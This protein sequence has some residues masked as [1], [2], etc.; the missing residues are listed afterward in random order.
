MA[1]PCLRDVLHGAG[2]GLLLLIAFPTRARARFFRAR[3]EPD[4]LE[5]QD[6]GKLELDMQVGALYGDGVDGSRVILPDMDLEI[7]I[8]S[9]LE[10][11]ID[12]AF[13]VTQLGTGRPELGGDPLWTSLRFELLNMEDED[14]DNF[15]VGLQVGPRFRTVDNARG[16]GLG[17]VALIGGGSKTLHAVGNFGTFVD[18]EQAVALVYGAGL[19]WEFELRRK[20]SLVGQL[21]GAHYFGE[22]GEDEDPDQTFLQFGFGTP[23]NDA[24]EVELLAVAGPFARG[25][26]AGLLAGITWDSRLW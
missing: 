11:D 18:Q 26:R 23:L 21:A 12:G 22:V 3:F 4:T 13:T 20:W 7:G 16:V 6:P 2:L 9:W 24:L 25:D 15:G 19:Q 1:R 17:A 14:G 10:I 5:L 8:A